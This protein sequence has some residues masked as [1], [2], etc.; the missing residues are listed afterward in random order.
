MTTSTDLATTTNSAP[1]AID[2]HAVLRHLKLDPKDPK[3]QAVVLVCDRYGLDPVLKHVVLVEGNVYISRDGLLHIAHKSGQFDGIEIIEQTET[4]TEWRAVASVHRKDMGRPITYPGRYSKQAMNKKNG[5][6]M[7]IARA[8]SMALRRAFSVAMVAIDE[9]DEPIDTRTVPSPRVQQVEAQRSLSEANA[10][11]FVEKCTEAGAGPEDV[12]TIVLA[13]TGGR[14]DDLAGVYSTE[15]PELRNALASWRPLSPQDDDYETGEI[16]DVSTP[17]TPA[18][19]TTE[20][21][22]ALADAPAP[23]GAIGSRAGQ[24]LHKDLGNMGIPGQVQPGI[25]R[26]GS[27]KLPDLGMTAKAGNLMPEQVEHVIAAAQWWLG[28]DEEAQ[29]TAAARATA[30]LDEAQTKALLSWLDKKNG[31]DQ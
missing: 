23:K 30:G 10:A 6:E 14:T 18:E 2:Q 12:K 11:R 19:P 29:V 8:E 1:V 4:D 15:V 24:N 5:P 16:V 31:A 25:I 17:S 20:A 26:A 7:A 28:L 21:K 22:E 13:A 3:A 27:S 9:V